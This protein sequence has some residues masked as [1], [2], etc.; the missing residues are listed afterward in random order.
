MTWARSHPHPCPA[1]RRLLREGTH[2]Q[3]VTC[4]EADRKVEERLKPQLRLVSQ[5][6][7][8]YWCGNAAATGPPWSCTSSPAQDGSSRFVPPTSTHVTARSTPDEVHVRVP[9]LYRN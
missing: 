8:P 4:G 9:A 7:R 1:P 6:R 2:E 5:V 3:V